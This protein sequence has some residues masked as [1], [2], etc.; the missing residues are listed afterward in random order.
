MRIKELFTI[1][2]GTNVTE[3]VFGKVLISSVCSILLC[4]ACLLGTTWAW[5]TV[6]VEN[7]D[8]EIQIATVAANVHV[9]DESMNAISEI[10]NGKYRFGQGTYTAHIQLESDATDLKS[11]VYVVVSASWDEETTYY[12]LTFENGKKEAK[13]KFLVG[14]DSADVSFS[15]S[16]VAP[17]S[18][19]VV[20]GAAIVV[21]EVSPG[22]S[23]EVTAPV[24]EPS[25]EV[26]APITQPSTE[27]TTVPPTEPSQ[28]ETEATQLITEPVETSPTEMTVA[29]QPTEEIA[30][31]TENTTDTQ[32]EALSIGQ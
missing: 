22:L 25:A 16:W 27:A 1:P 29:V 4:M 3:K 9:Q 28:A 21:G 2:E 19:N 15:V 12:Y 30:P 14:A 26:T 20:S 6:S 10:S 17:V 31:A 24:T 7:R 23:V 11:P 8:N 5:F 32:T 13:Q 18:A